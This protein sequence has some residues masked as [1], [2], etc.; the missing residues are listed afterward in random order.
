[1]KQMFIVLLIAAVGAG[2]YFYFNQRIPAKTPQQAEY[3]DLIV[4]AWSFDS[5][6]AGSTPTSSWEKAILYFADS[7]LRSHQLEFKSDSVLFTSAGGKIQD[8]AH[9]E[10]AEDKELFTW[11]NSDTTKEKFNIVKLDS[12]SL[13]IKDASNAVFYFQRIK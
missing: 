2:I 5:L 9:F 7:T 4:G 13:I 1:M 3:R 6:S 10:F 12:A 11:S 8:T